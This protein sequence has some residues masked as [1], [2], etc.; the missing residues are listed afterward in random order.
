MPETNPALSCFGAVFQTNDLLQIMKRVGE[1]ANLAT[2]A[3]ER[4]RSI[5]GIDHNLYLTW[6][7]D[8]IAAFGA[9]AFQGNLF[10]LCAP[11]EG[12]QLR[13]ATTPALLRCHAR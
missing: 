13:G 10:R 3:E 4:V 11:T 2:C 8:V 9:L 5:T 1:M 12:E 7:S 6:K